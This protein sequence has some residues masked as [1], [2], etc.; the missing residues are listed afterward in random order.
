VYRMQICFGFKNIFFFQVQTSCWP[1]L[2]FR[3]VFTETSQNRLKLSENFQS[4]IGAPWTK[5]L[6]SLL[7]KHRKLSRVSNVE[8]VGSSRSGKD[9]KRSKSDIVSED[10]DYEED[11]ES[12]SDGELEGKKM[13]KQK[14]ESVDS[15]Y[16]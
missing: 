12:R 11:E 7:K 15:F 4:G 1:N 8:N 3:P 13:K 10:T 9:G 2:E 16:G 5:F 6:E 14:K